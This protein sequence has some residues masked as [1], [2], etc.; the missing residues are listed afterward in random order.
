MTTL[1]LSLAPPALLRLHDVL[2]C[3]SKFSD[4]VAIEAEHDLVKSTSEINVTMPSR[5]NVG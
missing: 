3:L 4:T 1:S 5:R 2:I